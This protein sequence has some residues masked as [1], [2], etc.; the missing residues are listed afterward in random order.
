MDSFNHPVSG[1]AVSLTAGSGSS[2][3]T[4]VSGTSNG[5]GQATFTVK[6]ATAQ[7]VTYTAKDTTDSNLVIGTVTVTFTVGPVSPSTSTVVANPTS[8]VADGSSTSTITVTL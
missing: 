2:T 6:D 1:K 8:V 3:I 4:T 7:A 5:S